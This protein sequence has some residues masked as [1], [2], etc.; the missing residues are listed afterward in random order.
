MA[1]NVQADYNW[2][3]LT[4]MARPFLPKGMELEGK[5]SD[6]ISFSSTYPTAQ[7]A[8]MMTNLNANAAM[9]FQRADM[10]GLKFGPTELKLDVKQGRAAIDIPD[11]DVSGGKVRFTGD[12]DLSAK[13]MKLM[14]RQPMQVV[15][16]VKIDDVISAQ[17]LQYLNPVFAKG[18]N[19]SGIANLNCQTLAIPL[20]GATSSEILLDGSIGLKDVR[21]QSPLLQMIGQAAGGAMDLF[22]VPPTPFTVK[23]G[24]VQYADMPM[25]FGKTYAVHFL[26][27]RIGLEDKSLAMDVQVPLSKEGDPQAGRKIVLPLSGTLD[28]PKL[29]MSQMLQKQTEEVIKDVIQD[30]LK[31]IFK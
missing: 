21:L 22:T 10:M 13:P 17:L 11:A 20:A 31:D 25:F 5:R 12:V 18:T 2:A 26:R 19:V 16:N 4:A 24:L 7:P 9:G 6:T 30:K 15:E 28:R 8:K 1:G 27:C 3:D 14:L 29:D 23:N